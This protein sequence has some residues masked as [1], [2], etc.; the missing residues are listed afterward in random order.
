MAILIGSEHLRDLGKIL[1][2]LFN[3]NAVAGHLTGLQGE[4]RGLA[5]FYLGY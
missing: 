1:W 2:T 3:Q 5:T 4:H